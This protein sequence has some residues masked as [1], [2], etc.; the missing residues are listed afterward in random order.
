MAAHRATS[1]RGF[2][3]IPFQVLGGELD[4]DFS[5]GPRKADEQSSVQSMN[6]QSRQ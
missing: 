4:F 3:P 1:C 2:Q 5:V 6:F